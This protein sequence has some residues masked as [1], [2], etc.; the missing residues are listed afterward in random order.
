[1]RS[2]RDTEEE[3]VILVEDVAQ[4]VAAEFPTETASWSAALEVEAI[5]AEAETGVIRLQDCGGDGGMLLGHADG[6]HTLVDKWML[7]RNLVSH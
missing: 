3:E 2:E 6:A 4:G 5:F 1:M 7:C